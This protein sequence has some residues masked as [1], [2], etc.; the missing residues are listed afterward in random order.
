LN[1]SRG[2]GQQELADCS[3]VFFNREEQNQA[4]PKKDLVLP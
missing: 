1:S 4:D 2:R 3:A